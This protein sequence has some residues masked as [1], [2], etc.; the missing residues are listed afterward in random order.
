LIFA[1]V[2]KDY[3]EIG[4]KGA[5][6]CNLL[7]EELCRIVNSDPYT[8]ILVMWGTLQLTWVTMLL[9]VQL[10]QISRAMTTWE[11]MRGAHHG[12][13]HGSKASEAITSAL[14]TGT[15]SRAG[16][17]L[18]NSG[19]GPDPAL[20][21]THAQGGHHHHHKEGCFAQWKKILGIDTFVET[22][23][24]GYEGSKNRPRRQR[25]PFSVGCIQ[26]CKDFW[27][28]PA[29][30]F[31]KRENGEAVLGGEVVNYTMMYDTPQPHR[32]T[33]GGDGAAY[34]SVAGD[35]SV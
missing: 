33:R 31:G 13:G 7:A 6:E 28:D 25:N 17:Q 12:H 16:A 11:N 2:K 5:P 18:G 23:L 35:D 22:A 27:C 30:I 29:P 32:R 24:H 21:P 19:L 20:L 26:N 1:D 3:T 15:T 4:D 8:L 14:T 10:V 9:F 34:Q